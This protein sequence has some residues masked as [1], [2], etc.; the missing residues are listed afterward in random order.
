MS[1]P[2]DLR[3][4]GDGYS[5]PGIDPRTWISSATVDE[6]EPVVFD[7]ELGPLVGVTLQPTK[8]QVRCRVGMGVAGR[9]EGEYYPFVAGDEVLVAVP[10]GDLREGGV[11]LCRLCN[12]IDAFPTG[13]VAGQ[14]P[15]TNSFGFRRQKAPHAH[16]VD[17]PYLVR[18]S[19]TGALLSM[20]GAGVMTLRGGDGG[21]LQ[22]SPDAF[23]FQSADARFVLQLDATGGRFTL[24]VDD[25]ILTLSSSGAS[26]EVSALAV[27][28]LFSVSTATNPA[29]EHVLTTE[30]FFNLLQALVTA[31]GAALP[32]PIAGAALA[33]GWAAIVQAALLAAPALAQVPTTALAIVSAFA[34][35]AQKPPGV[36][37]QGQLRPGA[38]C[39]GFFAG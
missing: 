6:E 2:V 16:E 18:Q 7:A 30:A 34:A 31:I 39:A 8:E 22:L 12:S 27:P 14:D 24:K 38:G 33:A 11:I 29:A 17:G 37:L 10:R 4:V 3:T 13:S 23:G 25:S 19:S 5:Y 36:P 21:A 9:G 32:G 1:A 35:Q 28:G 15:V 26:P 20:D